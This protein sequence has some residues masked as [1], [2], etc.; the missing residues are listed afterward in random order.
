M[1]SVFQPQGPA[2]GQ[3]GNDRGD[4]W[5]DEPDHGPLVLREARGADQMSALYRLR[6]LC[7]RGSADAS[8]EDSHDD[9][10]THLWI[11][12][13]GGPPLAT[14][15]ARHHA[16][17]ASLG[18]GYS[19]GFF[20]L[21]P[22]AAQ[23]GTSLEIGRLCL[24]PRVAPGAAMRLVWRG[25]ARLRAEAG[26]RRL[27]GCTSLQGGAVE[28]HDALLAYLAA[29]HL[30]PVASRPRAWATMAHRFSA[31][32]RRAPERRPAMPTILRYYL[33][34][35]G[36]VSDEL[37]RDRDLDTCVLFTCVELDAMPPARRRLIQALATPPGMSPS[38]DRA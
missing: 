24:H 33:S 14:L 37:A 28:R 34:Q 38:T 15:R 22:M 23:P 32:A 35:G 30:G 10:C 26:A 13:P 25:V 21:A 12:R 31:A 5:A 20:D 29:R 36:W 9:G 1:S 4:E 19:A 3:R 11:G 16:D 2:P 8:D 18:A 27:I 7:F 6:G 17:A